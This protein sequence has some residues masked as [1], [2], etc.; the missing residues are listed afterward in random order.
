VALAGGAGGRRP[1]ARSLGLSAIGR[2]RGAKAARRRLT[3]DVGEVCAVCIDDAHELNVLVRAPVDLERGRGSAAGG[4]G[5]GQEPWDAPA[6]GRQSRRGAA[7][8]GRRRCTRGRPWRGIQGGA[9]VMVVGGVVVV[10]FLGHEWRARRVGSV[11]RF[12]GLVGDVEMPRGAC[13]CVC[14]RGQMRCAARLLRV[15]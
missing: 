10:L 15:R 5:G 3:V 7:G 6:G 2:A 9:V 8:R 11:S 1:T 12:R 14:C 4:S 13:V